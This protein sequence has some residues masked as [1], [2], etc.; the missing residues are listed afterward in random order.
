[1]ADVQHPA[2]GRHRQQGLPLHISGFDL[3]IR[4]AA[5][6]FGEHNVEILA[7]LGLSAGQIESLGEHEVITDIP[8]VARAASSPEGRP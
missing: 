7:A 4:R 3:A 6:R 1:V 2:A 8:A 5:P